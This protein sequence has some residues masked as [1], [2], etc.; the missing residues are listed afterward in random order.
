[1]KRGENGRGY[2][3]T[4]PI[5][6][7]PRDFTEMKC[8][9]FHPLEMFQHNSSHDLLNI[10]A[11]VQRRIL[12]HSK[13]GSFISAVSVPSISRPRVDEEMLVRSKAI[14]KLHRS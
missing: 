7:I 9:A 5:V 12:R 3:S 2:W 8:Q 11:S 1:M 14:H 4:V 6:S 10:C 13:I